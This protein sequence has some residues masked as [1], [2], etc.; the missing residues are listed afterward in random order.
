MKELIPL[1]AAAIGLTP[2]L[3][4]WLNDRSNAAANQKSIQFAKEQIEFW[5]IWLKAQREVSSDQRYE[6]IKAD[7]AHRL[8]ELKIKSDELVSKDK[9]SEQ[10]GDGPSFLQRI[11]LAYFPHTPAA[12]ILHTLFYITNTFTVFFIFVSSLPTDDLDANPNWEFF[13]TQ[14]DFVIPMLI[15]T[16][17]IAFIFQRFANRSEKKYRKRM[18][19]LKVQNYES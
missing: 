8:D 14:L 18:G 15:F 19:E 4:K 12:W 3:L 10:L 17:F 1:L 11:F 2:V 7:V 13:K 16:F 9:E 5:Q 6:K